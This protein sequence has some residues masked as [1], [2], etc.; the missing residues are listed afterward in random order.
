MI[1][2]IQGLH[3]MGAFA[4]FEMLFPPLEAEPLDGSLGERAS[5]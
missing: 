4:D 2:A 3:D 1:A 5:M